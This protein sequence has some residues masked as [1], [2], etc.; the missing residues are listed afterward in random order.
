MDC[1]RIL[2]DSAYERWPEGS[3]EA[4]MTREVE[5]VPPQTDLFALASR[6]RAGPHRRFPITD[7]DGK[8]L[9]LVT[10]RDVLRALERFGHDQSKARQSTTY[11]LIAHRRLQQG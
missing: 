8:L 5:A 3:V 7:T 9:G 6:F 1:L 2:S 4:N 10:R 11:E